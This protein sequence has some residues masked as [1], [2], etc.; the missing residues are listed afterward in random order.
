MISNVNNKLTLIMFI[1]CIHLKVQVDLTFVQQFYFL[2]YSNHY[3][4][5]FVFD[6]ADPELVKVFP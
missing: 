5:S 4:D 2:T 6:P 1:D 3:L